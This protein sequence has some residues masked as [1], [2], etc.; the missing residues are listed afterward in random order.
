VEELRISYELARNITKTVI[1]DAWLLLGHTN[2]KKF[3]V[4]IE[5]DHGMEHQQKFKRH[6]QAKIEFIRSG[7]YVKLFGTQ[8]VLI[9]YITT[10]QIPESRERRRKTMAL[11]T[12]EVLEELNLKNW[13]SIFRFHSLVLENIYNQ[14]IFEKP[15]WFTPYSSEPLHLLT[16]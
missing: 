12:K 16:P 13:A 15:V 6:I 5:L 3:P 10:G 9:A 14:S 8:A 4:M 2:G 7:Q 1:P 11:W